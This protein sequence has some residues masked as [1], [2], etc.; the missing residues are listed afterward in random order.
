LAR[1]A[2]LTGDRQRLRGALEQLSVLEADDSS[3]RKKLAA[4][5]VEDKDWERAARYAWMTLHIDVADADAHAMLADASAALGR[6]P[7]AVD[8]YRAVRQLKPKDR[9]VLIKLARAYRAAGQSAAAIE[10][11]QQLLAE[12]P[13]NREARELLK[14]LESR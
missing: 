3:P 4:M 12:D 2:L 5:A 13:E 9:S 10:A 8:E 11:A 14:A 7:D 1:I 6:W